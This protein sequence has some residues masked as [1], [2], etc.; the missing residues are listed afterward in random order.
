MVGP[1]SVPRAC[2]GQARA[3]SGPLSWSWD[4]LEVTRTFSGS[5]QDVGAWGRLQYRPLRLAVGSEVAGVERSP[6]GGRQ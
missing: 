6:T 5:G 2:T 1:G 4:R 3:E